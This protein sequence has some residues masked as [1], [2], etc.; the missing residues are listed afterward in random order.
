MAIN[1]IKHDEVKA[2]I[3]LADIGMINESDV[4]LAK[5]SNALLVGFNVK[6]GVLINIIKQKKDRLVF[7]SKIDKAKLVSYPK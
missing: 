6:A 5:A 4:S 7:L 2:N 3:I 1:K